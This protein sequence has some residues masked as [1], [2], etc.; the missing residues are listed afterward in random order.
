M[1]LFI[2][3]V[4]QTRRKERRSYCLDTE[5]VG[6]KYALLH[7]YLRFSVFMINLFIEC[8]ISFSVLMFG[9]EDCFLSPRISFFFLSNA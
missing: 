8:L 1:R 7:V 2:P 5:P 3:Q 6:V 4:K 9:N